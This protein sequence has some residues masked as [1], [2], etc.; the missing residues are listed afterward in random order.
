MEVH[1]LNLRSLSIMTTVA[2]LVDILSLSVGSS[3]VIDIVNVSLYSNK[4]SSYTE[5]L[6]GTLC[7]PADNTTPYGPDL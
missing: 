4:L 1:K 3:I 6:N 2:I 5:M 7:V